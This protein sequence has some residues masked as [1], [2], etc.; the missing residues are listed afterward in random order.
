MRSPP[1]A[2]ALF[3]PAATLS[4]AR[5]SA[6]A[7]W[8][9]VAGG[10][11]PTTATPLNPALGPYR[12]FDW[13]R[14]ELD[15]LKEVRRALGGTLN[16]LVLS[17]VAG[18]VGRF[19]ARRGT[20]PDA[21]TVFR[22][23]VPVSTRADA[24]RGQPGNR[25]VNF[26]ARLPVHVR[27][28]VERL[29]CTREETSRL[30]ASRLVQGA[31]L[32]AQVGDRTFPS[33]VVALIQLAAK[34][35][36]YNLVVTNVPGPQRPLFLR[37]A[38]M[39]EIYPLVPL[40]SGQGLGVALFSYDDQ[41]LWGFNADWDALPD[42]HE[43]VEGV[44]SELAALREAARRSAEAARE[45]G[46]ASPGAEVPAAGPSRPRRARARPRPQPDAAAR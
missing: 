10:L 14:S 34:G 24:E 40:F 23:M 45:P 31:E 32:L 21:G 20:P 5:E 3:A 37:G 12:R 46:E 29:A 25:V 41:L 17:S 22:A 18:A 26:L 33:L 36:A 8:E 4:A 2:G 30:K 9:T 11:A 44:E 16:D 13:L 35:R 28:P 7:A 27:D 1:R 38:R 19:L 43:F 39:R 15:P 6:L 42:L